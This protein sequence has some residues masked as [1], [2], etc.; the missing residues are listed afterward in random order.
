MPHEKLNHFFAQNHYLG[1]VD[2][3]CLQQ[4]QRRL[5][6]ASSSHKVGHTCGQ[7]KVARGVC[8][9]LVIHRRISF[10]T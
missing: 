9:I 8:Y 5:R 10:L 3:Q 1:C 2:T 4:R 6:S 7:I